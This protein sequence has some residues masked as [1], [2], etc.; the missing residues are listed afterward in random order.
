MKKK[1]RCWGI[2][3]GRT[4][5]TSLCSALRT[6]GYERVEHNPLFEQL[7][8]LDGGTDNGVT[9]FYKYLDYK[10]PGSRFILTERDLET[11]LISME[12]INSI[13]PVR[14]TDEDVPIM[15]RMALYETVEFDLE[16]Y[17]ASYHRHRADVIRYFSGR[18]D[19]L[20]MN[21]IDGDGWEKLCPFLGLDAPLSPFPHLNNKR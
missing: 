19:L 10:F 18:D 13:F 6:L 16:K 17:T 12:Y 15:R 20:I 8:D 2:G 1:T 4:G 11:W 3:L 5:T 9:V 7:R 21:I 14:S